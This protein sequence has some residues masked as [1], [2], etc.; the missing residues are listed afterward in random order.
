M[1]KKV[2]LIQ[3]TNEMTVDID[4]RC[5]FAPDMWSVPFEDFWICSPQPDGVVCPC[6]GKINDKNVHTWC[7]HESHAE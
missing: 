3:Q 4:C 7:D 5:L 1:K 6:C 2:T